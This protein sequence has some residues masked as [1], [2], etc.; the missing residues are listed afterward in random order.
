AGIDTAQM[1]KL[2]MKASPS[3]INFTIEHSIDGDL[4]E[5]LD[6][7]LQKERQEEEPTKEPIKSVENEQVPV[8]KDTVVFVPDK[9]L[10]KIQL[11]ALRKPTIINEHFSRLLKN[12]PGTI[13]TETPGEDGI[14]RYTTGSFRS[15]KES[16]KLIRIIR[17]LG[18]PDSFIV[19]YKTKEQ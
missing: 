19:P 15:R 6:F 9:F 11:L 17:K 4:A 18:W 2:N 8:A 13:I 1:R 16:V 10:Y 12:V 5:G 3:F 7:V 14:Y